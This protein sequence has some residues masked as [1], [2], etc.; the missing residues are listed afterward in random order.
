M[1]SLQKSVSREAATERREETGAEPMA[2]KRGWSGLIFSFLAP[3]NEQLEEMLGQLGTLERGRSRSAGR[4]PARKSP[5]RKSPARKS[6]ARSTSKSRGRSR[7]PTRKKSPGRPAR[8]SLRQVKK[9]ETPKAALESSATSTPT[10][11]RTE[12]EK[13]VEVKDVYISIKKTDAVVGDAKSLRPRK[14][15]VDYS[16]PRLFT[17][18]NEVRVMSP[19]FTINQDREKPREV[20]HKEKPSVWRVLSIVLC[21]FAIPAFALILN[22]FCS[23]ENECTLTKLPKFSWKPELYFD[24]HVF[25]YYCCFVMVQ[26]IIQVLPIGRKVK[27]PHTADGRHEYRLN[28]I[29]AVIL[30]LA[31]IPIFHHYGLDLSIVRDKFRQ[32][33]VSAFVISV[34]LSELAYLKAR[35]QPSRHANPD[36]TTGNLVVDWHRGQELTPRLGPLDLKI[37]IFRLGLLGMAFFDAFLVYLLWRKTGMISPTLTLA[38]SF[39]IFTVFSFYVFEEDFFTTMTYTKEGMGF[40][41]CTFSTLIPAIYTLNVRLLFDRL[42][43]PKQGGSMELPWYCLASI[44]LIFFVGFVIYTVSNWQKNAFKRTPYHPGLA[45]LETIST[46]RGKLIVSGLWGWVRHPNYLG[47]IIMAFCWAALCGIHHSIPYII[48]VMVLFMLCHRAALDATICSKKYGDAYDKEYCK[49]VPYKVIPKI[50]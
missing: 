12:R 40:V 36:G 41:F 2:T 7:T 34:F 28:G 43:D 19:S 25:G 38:A 17:R 46:P 10:I 8:L 26:L 27:G 6:P 21:T 44:A 50:Y 31:T 5:A 14:S 37:F 49:R 32:L 33:I 39:A 22:A 45:N 42:A 30:T 9:P 20:K 48:P 18:E 35:L 3:K 47:D 4:S 16:M 1:A 29:L 15:K 13:Q 23:K 24:I 11:T